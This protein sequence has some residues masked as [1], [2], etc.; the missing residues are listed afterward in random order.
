MERSLHRRHRRLDDRV[1]DKADERRTASL[2][3]VAIILLLLVG[4]LFLVQRLHRSSTIEDCLMAGHR[5]CDA[6]VNK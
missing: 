3:G 5:D 2:V 6:L 1:I 4:G